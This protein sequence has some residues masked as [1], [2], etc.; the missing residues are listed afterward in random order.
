M[1]KKIENAFDVI[2]WLKIV[3]SPL[4]IG[5]VLGLII[6]IQVTGISG[7]ILAIIVAKIGLI[8]GI[9]WANRIW[10]KQG[11]HNFM[12]RINAS[13]DLDPKTTTKKG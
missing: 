8:I 10:K 7:F 6:Y 12:S 11:T 13:E 4:I 5:C 9:I 3:A 1:S 2:A